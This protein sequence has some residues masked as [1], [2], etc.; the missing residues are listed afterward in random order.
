MTSTQAPPRRKRRTN[1][2]RLRA[3]LSWVRGTGAWELTRATTNAGV[4][5]C[6]VKITYELP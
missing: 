1:R 5:Y 3:G 6:S 2:D 4:A